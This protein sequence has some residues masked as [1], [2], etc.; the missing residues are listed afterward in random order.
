MAY[1][2][3]RNGDNVYYRND[4]DRD[5]KYYS[6]STGNYAG[7]KEHNGTYT[8]RLGNVAGYR[9]SNGVFYDRAGNPRYKKY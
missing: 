3:N 1:I 9:A 5:H 4:Y 6:C 8:D 7:R 2:K